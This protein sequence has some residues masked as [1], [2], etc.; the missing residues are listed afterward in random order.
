MSSPPSRN[1]VGPQGGSE[2]PRLPEKTVL[3]RSALMRHINRFQTRVALIAVLVAALAGL[4]LTA[5]RPSL[6]AA[7]P[8]EVGLS[9]QRLARINEMMQRHIA[10]GEISGGVTLVARKGRVAHF[11]AHGTTDLETRRPMQKDSVFRIA[12]MTKVV[13]GVA[14]MMMVE[15]GRIR[16][17]DPVSKF[18]PEFRNL[19]VAIEQEQPRQGPPQTNGQE[20]AA[21]NFYR[22]PAAREVT[23][24]DLLTHTSGLASGPMGNS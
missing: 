6:P 24:R 5:A 3:R 22:V 17:T 23:V 13:T 21:P 15:E 18:I 8:E 9:T 7:K 2:D 4:S 20:P 11:E 19:T 14:V 12:S 16:I 10:A 1:R